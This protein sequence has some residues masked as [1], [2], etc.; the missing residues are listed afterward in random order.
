MLCL[1]KLFVNFVVKG[2][3][4]IKVSINLWSNFKQKGLCTVVLY[5][6][7]AIMLIVFI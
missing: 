6:L 1:A 5:V 3:V 2:T 4:L 7:Y